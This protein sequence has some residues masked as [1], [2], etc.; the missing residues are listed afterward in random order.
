MYSPFGSR[1]Q[2]YVSGVQHTI[3]AFGVKG[4]HSRQATCLDNACIESFFSHLKTEKLYL[5]QCKSGTD[6]HQAVEDYIYF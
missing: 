2:V 1:L 3:R 5:K 4:S 6:I